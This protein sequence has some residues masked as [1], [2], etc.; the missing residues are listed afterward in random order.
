MNTRIQKF[1][2]EMRSRS[3]FRA[4]VAYSVASWMLLQVADVTFD[5]LPLPD[6]AMTILIALV[7]TGYPVTFILAWG[8]E[9]TRKGIV[10]HAQT[11]GGAPRM[12]ITSYIVLVVAVSVGAAS[13]LYYF[14][15]KLWEPPPRSI[16][17]LPFENAASDADTEYFADGLTEEIQNLI[18]RLNE[19]RVIA[20]T[21]SHRFKDTVSDVMSIAERLDV[22]VV[23]QGSVRRNQDGVRV[24]AR[25]IDGSNGLSIWAETYER[26]LED[27]TTIQ[28]DIARQVARA[29]HV[30]L[31]VSADRRLA[32]LGTRNIE[33]YDLYLRGL[34]Y[35][36]Q[37]L[38]QVTLGLA[39]TNLRQAL[40]LDPDFV[41]AL[42]AVCQLHLARYRKT[43]D[44][45]LFARAESACEQALAQDSESAA[46]YAALGTLYFESGEYEQAIEQ[47]QEALEYSPNYTDA[48][49]GIG[50]SLVGLERYDEAE[51]YLRSAIEQDVSYWASFNSM[52]NF[53]FYRSRFLEAA[54]FYKMYIGRANDDSQAYNN[55][56][57]AYYMAG[58]FSRA[59]DA[60]ESSLAI[61]A[62]KSSFSNT[63]LMY[64]YLGEFEEA[65]NRFAQAVNLSPN[66]YVLWGN[67]ADAYFQIDAM[68]A[69]ATTAYQRAVGLA[70]AKL[71]VNPN[72]MDAMSSLAYYYSRTGNDRAAHDLNDEVQSLGADNMYVHFTSA[73]I[74]AHYGDT[75][76]ALDAVDRALGSGFQAVMLTSEPGLQLL[77]DNAQFR[78]MMENAGG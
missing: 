43:A 47:Y 78:H 65:A 15:E 66:D 63:G 72:D 24:N 22:D 73:L 25:L 57:A 61:K 41:S 17:V 16:A 74:Y 39:E 71:A 3:V 2:A 67:L 37:P 13:L 14:A 34:D 1:F 7:V 10:R 12:E 11:D 19:F 30:V 36:R 64:Y 48:Y 58:D 26:K 21:T 18:V 60:W 4:L 31:P 23:L 20:L 33:A 29:L 68:E 44:A 42:A 46:I 5:R 51:Q 40:V 45:A 9:F 8:Y 27:S 62:T 49:I 38:D 54:E 53:L 28:E 76:K 6:N 32:N 35:L 70:E 50:D 69:A 52:G 56:G 55:L 77:H 75:E 59:A